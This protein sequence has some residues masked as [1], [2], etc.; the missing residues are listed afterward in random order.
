MC[1]CVIFID[2]FFCTIIVSSRRFLG[3]A[4]FRFEP[5]ELFGHLVV[6]PLWE[7]SND[8]EARFVHGDA[9]DERICSV[10][11]DLLA[12]VSEL[13]HGDT[14]DAILTGKAVVL[15]RHVQLV[16]LRAV[17]AA[18]NT[19]QEREETERVLSCKQFVLDMVSEDEF[20]KNLH[21]QIRIIIQ[22]G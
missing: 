13:Q 9:A 15:Q 21:M 7:D 4:G 10:Q 20:L 18:Q 11:A 17:L 14:D 16:R 6:G 2:F 8:G 5:Y 22:T 3:R 19:A 12:Q 1:V